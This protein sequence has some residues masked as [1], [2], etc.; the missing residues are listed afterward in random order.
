MSKIYLRLTWNMPEISLIYLNGF[1][2]RKRFLVQFFFNF[3]KKKFS[4]RKYLVWKKICYMRKATPGSALH[5]RFR[6]Y[7][8]SIYIRGA[9]IKKNGKIW[10][11]F[12]NGGVGWIFFSKKSQFQFGNFAH[13]G[14]GLN[15]SKMSQS[16]LFSNYFA[17]L[18]L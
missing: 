3:I 15:I 10:E 16:Q 8:A 14:G 17:I 11:K 9:I 2:V 1:L 13:P 18:P 12:P 6:E 4:F 7:K 5:T